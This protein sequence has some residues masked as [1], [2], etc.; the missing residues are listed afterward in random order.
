MLRLALAALLALL[1]ATALAQAPFCT[2][3]I[4]VE[5]YETLVDKIDGAFSLQVAQLEPDKQVCAQ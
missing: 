1:A 3:D 2:A 4:G 5:P